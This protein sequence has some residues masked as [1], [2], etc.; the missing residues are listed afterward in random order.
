MAVIGAIRK[1]S[2]LLLIIIGGALLIFI[3]QLARPDNNS[4]GSRRRKIEPVAEIF[5]KEI[6]YREFDFEIHQQIELQK[7]RNPEYA[8]TSMELFQLKQQHFQKKVKEYVYRKH[9]EE[10][11]LAIDNEY[12]T[13]P[14]ISAAEFRDML[15]GNDPHPEVRRAFTNQQTGQF[16]PNSVRQV[17]ENEDQMEVIQR[18]QWK[19]FIEE[20]KKERLEN[21]YKNMVAKSFYYPTAL[22][23]IA[24]HDTRDEVTFRFVGKRYDTVHDSLVVI[25]D[26][27]YKRYYEEHRTE[28]DREA[29]AT[30]NYVVFEARP[31]Q[32]DVAEIEK[33]F[34]DLFEGFKASENPDVFVNSNS[35]DRY[36]STWFRKGELPVMLDSI[37]FNAGKGTLY[38]P[39]VESSKYKAATVV[40]VQERPDSIRA[41][42]ILIA[43]RGAER[44]A[45][46]VTRLQSEAELYADSILNEVKANPA[47]F[48]N[49]A[50]TVS[51]DA[52]ART[53]QGDLKWFT[54]NAMAPE[55]SA[56]CLKTDVG[57]FVKSQT[58]FG[59][60]IIKVTGKKD[61]SRQVRV[62]VLTQDIE[63]S[64]ETIQVEYSRASRFAQRIKSMETFEAELEKEGMAG[65]EVIVNKDM[66]TVQSL[67]D[68]RE[69]VRWAMNE[70]TEP[71]V[72]SRMFEF[73][74]KYQY[75]VCIVKSR[76][77]KGIW[78]LDDELKGILEPLVMREKKHEMIAGDMKKTG[79]K[80]LYRIAEKMNLK[81]DTATISYNMSNLIGWGPEVSVIG[82]AFGL[83]KGKV[84]E[85]IK[86]VISSFMILV[87]EKNI[88]L[89]PENLMDQK[90]NEERLFSQL[91]QQNFDRALEKAA[92]ITDN[93]LLWY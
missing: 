65:S 36:D 78:E 10:I 60:H 52:Y 2:T 57:E 58:V 12:S 3:I 41:S 32:R 46:N 72:T 63:P 49:L 80:D 70:D 48:E 16:D 42:H 53:T 85:P 26:E 1:R 79:S 11:G 9:C 43:Y 44:A 68:G 8:P 89:E 34:M 6:N 21:K 20:I 77:V 82:T 75:V 55:F 22:A 7:D 33:R 88:A 40:D 39:F 51:D 59:Y 13:V 86:G 27:D 84:T 18:L 37:L 38:G 4:G 92:N 61:F 69:I 87:D 24:F 81:V 54:E 45:E 74:D 67:Q 30:L 64:R 50:S 71:G 23:K 15:M 35:H 31:S 14:S 73:P 62:A 29:Q 25:T 56:A 91:V 28:Y 83:P 19:L 5:D 66:Y 17:L 90:M 93:R 76:R 47:L